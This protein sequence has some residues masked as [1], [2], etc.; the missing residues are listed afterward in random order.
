MRH[1]SAIVITLALA[2][3][4]AA[5][6]SDSGGLTLG[7][8]VVV[9]GTA[10]VQGN[11]FSVGGSTFS[12]AAGSI[13]LG[14]RLNAA[15]GGIKWA[16]GSTSTTAAAVAASSVFTTT[17]TRI[18]AYLTTTS[19]DWTPV[20]GATV[21]LTASG[22]RLLMSFGCDLN[23]N[24]GGGYRAYGGF[25]VNGAYIDGETSSVG[26]VSAFPSGTVVNEISNQ[27]SHLTESTYSG[28]VSIVPIYKTQAGGTA[29]VNYNSDRVC[30]MVVTEL[31]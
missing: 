2:S 1:L 8:Q 5:D 7:G 19:S 26:F 12:V 30:Q 22:G 29:S 15:A 10:T 23:Q 21:T 20:T 18:T 11:A 9:Q 14:G 24:S 16:D 25:L 3:P 6:I 13:T 17:F 28:S 4:A 27:W 31:K